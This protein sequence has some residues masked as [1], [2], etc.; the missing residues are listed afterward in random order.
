M[1]R[2]PD[3]FDREHEWADLVAFVQQR[4]SG[5]RLAIVRGRRRQGKSFL[6]RRLAEATGGFYYQA[7]E[8]ERSQALDAL[9]VAA[10]R[11]FEVPGGKL[12]FDSWDDAISAVTRP[13]S[14]DDPAVVI[15]DELPYLLAHSP[16]LPSVLQRHID[17]SG[18]RGPRVRLIVCGSALS[19]MAGLLAGTKALRGR[20][21][22]DVVVGSFDYRTA[23]RFWEL[24][25]AR[26]AFH[27]HAVLG[28][29]PGYRDL[30]AA[31]PPRRMADLSRW[32]EQTVLDPGSALFR[33]DDYLLRE[34]RSLSDRAL[35]HA[36]VGATAAPSTGSPTRSCA[37]TTPSSVPTL[38]ASR[39]AALPTR[40]QT[41]NRGSRHTS[42]ART[43]SCCPASSPSGSRPPTPWAD[44][45]PAS[46]PPS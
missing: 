10:G 46:G 45:L 42:S 44:K 26:V 32:I 29:T 37:S 12:A 34:E 3:L 22:H 21:G 19:V 9:G 27:L 28:G 23:A 36:V 40:G 1:E 31:R 7:L 14:T 20:A 11:H 18:G 5:T 2:S 4:A 35:Y 43:S 8:Q 17:A 39:T 30:V 13:R 25:D 38:P 41:P 24:D 16:E 33:E 15:I 6:L